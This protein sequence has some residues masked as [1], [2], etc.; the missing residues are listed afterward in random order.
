L[1]RSCCRRRLIGRISERSPSS[2]DPILR[3]LPLET[4]R[5]RPERAY[6]LNI[7]SIQGKT[8]VLLHPQHEKSEGR[9]PLILLRI[10]NE[11]LRRLVAEPLQTFGVNLLIKYPSMARLAELPDSC[12]GWCDGKMTVTLESKPVGAVS[13][14]EERIR[15]I[16]SDIAQQRTLTTSFISYISLTSPP[17]YDEAYEVIYNYRPREDIRTYYLRKGS[18]SEA[19][20]VECNPNTPSPSCEFKLSFADQP[21]LQITY[22]L[23]K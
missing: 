13:S 11:F 15:A 20:F 18:A 3:H 7:Q 12:R 23:S 6:G 21:R 5:V 10:P 1:A 16:H 14:A 2:D 19:E 9:G 22:R 4:Q 17:D 8:A